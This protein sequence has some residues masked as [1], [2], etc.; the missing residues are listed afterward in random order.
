MAMQ[1][2]EV[3]YESQGYPFSTAI[4]S[5]ACSQKPPPP[6]HTHPYDPSQGKGEAEVLAG[7]KRLKG[8]ITGILSA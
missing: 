7:H 3:F 2:A 1:F 4:W 8:W 5:T 6:T